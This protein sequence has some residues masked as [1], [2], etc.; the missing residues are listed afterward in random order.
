MMINIHKTLV[1]SKAQAIKFRFMDS[2]AAAGDRNAQ[3]MLFPTKK[4][5]SAS[6]Y[7]LASANLKDIEIAPGTSKKIP[8]GIAIEMPDG[9]EAQIR[10][11]SGLAFKH[12]VTLLNAPGTIDA[13]YRGEIAILLINHGKEKFIVKRGMRIAQMV[14]AQ[15]IQTE[16]HL[17]VHLSES[18]RGSKGFGSTGI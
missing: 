14:F 9:I 5:I 1:S 16:L 15:V 3:D 11:R 6:G 18:L 17:S 4:S 8:T 7:D 13:D 2:A 10:P 12:Q